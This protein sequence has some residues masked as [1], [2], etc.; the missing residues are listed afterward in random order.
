M[1]KM[2]ACFCSFMTFITIIFHLLEILEAF[3]SR[4]CLL[5]QRSQGLYP[6]LF[7][8][9]LSNMSNTVYNLYAWSPSVWFAVKLS[10]KALLWGEITDP[11]LA[12][13]VL[14][15]EKMW[16]HKTIIYSSVNKT[17]FSKVLPLTYS[18]LMILCSLINILYTQYMPASLSLV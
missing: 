14:V 3:Y 13:Q 1:T 6:L 15:A 12:Q 8:K 10:I 16:V 18:M 5:S 4:Y 2:P 17:G 7:C 11:Q 9:H